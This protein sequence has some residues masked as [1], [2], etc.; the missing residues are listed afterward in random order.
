MQNYI[1]EV[2]K[3]FIKIR[4]YIEVQLCTIMPILNNGVTKS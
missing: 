1:L 4:K 2:Q 3:I